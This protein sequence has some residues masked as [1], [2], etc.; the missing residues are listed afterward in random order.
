MGWSQAERQEPF[1]RLLGA[2]PALI[3]QRPVML[4]SSPVLTGVRNT[5]SKQKAIHDSPPSGPLPKD[6]GLIGADDSRVV[7][8]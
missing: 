3:R 6:Y 5:M 8:T 7:R 1:A 4:A 2:L